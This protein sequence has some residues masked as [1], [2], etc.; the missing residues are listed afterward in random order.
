[1]GYTPL[2]DSLT[3]G[4]L[5]GRWPDIG[6]WPI[7][8]SLADRHGV[9]DV[10]PE[11]IAGATGLSPEEV[12]ECMRRFCAPDPRSRS[13]AASGAR[14]AL[15]DAHREWGWRVVNHAEY[16]EKARL[17][18]KSERATEDGSNAAR[19]RD[20]RGP[21]KTAAD[22]LSDSDSDSKNKKGARA[23][24][25]DRHKPPEALDLG[26]WTRWEAYRREIRRPLKPSSVAAGQDELAKFGK[27]QAAVVQQSIANGYQ[28]LF[29]LKAAHG[30]PA[31]AATLV[32]H[33]EREGRELRALCE[34][35]P[36]I[37]L[38]DFREPAKGETS[39]DYRKAQDSEW[40]RRKEAPRNHTPRV[41]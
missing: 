2:F 40:D 27:D 33:E 16:R 13:P 11:R 25:G 17:L 35:R 22:R 4:T 7:V 14:L 10:T 18:S 9:V 38:R 28:G 3:D 6:L 41:S 19:M 26:A 21:P 15:L 29:E 20:R 8:L 36:S 1:M 37:G 5:Y 34:R 23:T 32:T 12:A 39:S 30:A 24:A 31:K